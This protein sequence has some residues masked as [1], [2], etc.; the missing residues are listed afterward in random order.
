MHFEECY[1]MA[2]YNHILVIPGRGDTLTLMQKLNETA[3][4]V[5]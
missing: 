4:K 2:S 5:K 3:N 1:A